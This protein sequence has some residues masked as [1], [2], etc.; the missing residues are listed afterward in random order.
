MTS[1]THSLVAV[2]IAAEIQQPLFAIPLA[3]ASN[4]ILDMVPHWD[5]GFGWRQKSK[6]KLFLEGTLDVVV[7]YILV[8]LIYFRFLSYLN[9]FFVF[10][11]VFASQLPDWL[12]IPYLLLNWKNE[13]FH[14]FYKIQHFIHR[15]L[16]LPWGIV[17]QVA[18][19]L[20]LL[21]LT[22]R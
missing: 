13:P 5:F 16:D 17:P 11:C 12:E 4:F 15:K 22:L 7:S 3:F 20:P 9:P 14:F 1:T 19:V 10:A 6:T 2:A 8:T 21:Y 18:I